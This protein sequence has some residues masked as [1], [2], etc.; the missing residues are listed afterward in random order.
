MTGFLTSSS[1]SSGKVVVVVVGN[2][3]DK[4]VGPSAATEARGTGALKLASS[5]MSNWSVLE[6]I[7]WIKGSS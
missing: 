4:R 1:L 5:T 6:K 7:R 3:P 2:A